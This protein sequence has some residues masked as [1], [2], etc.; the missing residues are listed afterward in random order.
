M[1]ESPAPSARRWGSSEWHRGGKEVLTRTLLMLGHGETEQNHVPSRCLAGG[2]VPPRR[3]GGGFLEH[4]IGRTPE[5]LQTRKPQPKDDSPEG[6]TEP[7]VPVDPEESASRGRS[8]G[9]LH[10]AGR[11]HTHQTILQQCLLA[12]GIPQSP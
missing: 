5:K 10:R 7:K 12:L 9:P 2:G 8:S 3:G 6:I 11:G 4:S 1:N